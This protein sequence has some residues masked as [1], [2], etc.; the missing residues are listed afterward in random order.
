MGG[1]GEGGGRR[2]SLR[3]E[4]L[5]GASGKVKLIKFQSDLL[6]ADKAEG[7]GTRGRRERNRKCNSFVRRKRGSN[8]LALLP[9]LVSVVKIYNGT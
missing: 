3:G 6:S 2:E 8:F 5:N 7:R 4:N 9:F 1:R